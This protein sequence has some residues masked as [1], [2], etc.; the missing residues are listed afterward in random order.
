MSY[1][2]VQLTY[3]EAE[4]SFYPDLS[5]DLLH[6][7]TTFLPVKNQLREAGVKYSLLHPARLQ[8]VFDG[9]KQEFAN[10]SEAA[11]LVSPR[12]IRRARREKTGSDGMWVFNLML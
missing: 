12:F 6:R 7:R 4:I 9:K 5:A 11:G 8:F 1:E 3:Q 10:P 2:R